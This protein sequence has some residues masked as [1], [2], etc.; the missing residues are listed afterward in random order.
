MGDIRSERGRA[1]EEAALSL[2]LSLGF[3][4][5]ARNWRCRAGEIDLVVSRGDL[6]VFCEVKTR[7]SASFGGGYEAV[8]WTKQRKLRQLAELFLQAER[9]RPSSIRFDVASV[10]RVSGGIPGVE[11]YEDAF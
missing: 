4:E 6:L 1:G 3:T 9:A 5:V 8:T 10:A 2:Y 7:T 11:L